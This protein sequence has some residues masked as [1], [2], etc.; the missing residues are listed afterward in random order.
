MQTGYHVLMVC[1]CTCLQAEH[2]AMFDPPL[3][4]WKVQALFN[5]RIG[6]ADKVSCR[7]CC[8]KDSKGARSTSSCAPSIP[9]NTAINT[10][11]ITYRCCKHLAALA[12]PPK[13]LTCSL[14]EQAL[15]SR[16]RRAHTH[17]HNQT[18]TI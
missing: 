1:F 5:I 12:Y 7:Q 10:S 13:Q 15:P 6:V 18:S 14:Q 8:R 4:D 11:S 9:S 16:A 2:A 17:T 3:P